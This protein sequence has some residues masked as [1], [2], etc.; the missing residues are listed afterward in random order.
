MKIKR[1]T[2]ITLTACLSILLAASGNQLATNEA[3]AA[4]SH[5]DSRDADKVGTGLRKRVS[6]SS[7]NNEKVRVVLQL[8]G[9]MSDRLTTLLNRNGIRLTK[10]FRN[11]NSSAIELPP[12]VVDELASYE[13][14]DFVTQDDDVMPL[15][16]VSSTTGADLVSSPTSRYISNNSL[17]GTG[18]GIAIID[19]GIYSSHKSLSARVVYSQ[20]FTGEGRVD[21]PYGHGTHVAS[22]AAG[23]GSLY[24]ANYAGIAPNANLINLRVLDSHGRGSMSMVLSA[25]DWVYSNRTTY[26]IRVVNMSLGAPA[27]SS[28]KNDPL[29]LAVRKLVD[30]GVVV[31][32][33]RWQ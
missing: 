29:C 16:H 19:S 7:H 1:S 14:V 8:N 15:G 4:G 31:V 25:L 10:S 24:N 6:N 32:G 33:S 3:H 12:A 20:D 27:L 11:F 18:V 23:N 2:S 28:Y 21:D 5:Q 22:A 9:Q 26:N 13:E 17:D 30:A